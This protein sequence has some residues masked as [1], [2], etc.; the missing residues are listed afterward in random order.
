[1]IADISGRGLFI[2]VDPELESVIVKG[3]RADRNQRF[4]SAQEFYE[5]LGG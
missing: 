2:E 3:C 4:G 1:M 5:A